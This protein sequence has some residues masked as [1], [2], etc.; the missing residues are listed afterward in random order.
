M[1]SFPT[2]TFAQGQRRLSSRGL[3]LCVV[4]LAGLAGCETQPRPAWRSLPDTRPAATQHQGE[5]LVMGSPRLRATLA[6]PLAW[7]D[8]RNDARLTTFAGYESPTFEQTVTYTYDRQHSSNGR[9]YNHTSV[10]TY[11]VSQQQTVR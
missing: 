2:T 8:Y 10:T 3:W 9:V 6:Q 7:Y 4:L 5:S 11:T 1:P